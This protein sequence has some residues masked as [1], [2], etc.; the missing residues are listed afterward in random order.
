MEKKIEDFLPFYLGCEVKGS[1]GTA[2]YILVGV[3]ND[4]GALF[5]TKEGFSID[6]GHGFKILLRQISDMTEEE[7]NFIFKTAT[8]RSLEIKGD[9]SKK[10]LVLEICKRL[11]EQAWL[12]QYLLS[13]HF[14][15]FNLIPSGLAI[16]KS[17]IIS[18]NTSN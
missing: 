4:G 5:K 16:D 7:V 8:L 17:K 6:P 12:F 13:K 3:T 11:S 10:K 15:L 2:T 14:D 18:P 1:E 9:F